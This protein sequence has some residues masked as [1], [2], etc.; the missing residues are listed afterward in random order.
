MAAMGTKKL[1]LY[2]LRS[3]TPTRYPKRPLHIALM[4][5]NSVTGLT[6]TAYLKAYVNFSRLEEVFILMNSGGGSGN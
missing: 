3:D 2:K 4:P 6:K 5:I 1:F